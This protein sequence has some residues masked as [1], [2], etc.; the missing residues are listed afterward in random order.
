MCLGDTIKLSPGVKLM[1][2]F[3]PQTDLLHPLPKH[4]GTRCASADD[5]LKTSVGP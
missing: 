3:R 2:S 4:R 5:A 1:T